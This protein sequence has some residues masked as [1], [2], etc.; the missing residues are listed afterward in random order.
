MLII[1][2]MALFTLGGARNAFGVLF[3]PITEDMGWTRTE[4]AGAATLGSLAMG[5]GFF[6]AGI[7]MDRYGPRFVVPIDARV[8]PSIISR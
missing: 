5:A 7:A 3:K 6:I 2:S 1:V 8:S 4:L